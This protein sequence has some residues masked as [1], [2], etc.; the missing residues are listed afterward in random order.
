MLTSANKVGGWV[1]KG[2]KH[3]DVILEWSLTYQ[4]LWHISA[5]K[6]IDFRKPLLQIGKR[7]LVSHIIDKQNAKC[8]FIASGQNRTITFLPTCIPNLK[9]TILVKKVI[10][11]SFN[12]FLLKFR[13]STKI[14]PIF[15]LPSRLG[16]NQNFQ[17]RFLKE[18][19]TP[20]FPF[21]I[22]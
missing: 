12:S 1:K 10:N 5:G 17:V 20:K 13:Y 16:Q 11:F 6:F 3:A 2:Q 14:C 8:I 21:E 15:H 18:L 22:Y 7:L 4:Q 19:K 9:E